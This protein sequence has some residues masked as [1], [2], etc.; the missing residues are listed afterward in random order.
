MT[1]ATAVR[2]GDQAQATVLAF[3]DE[4][5]TLG[6]LPRADGT[7]AVARV[8]QPCSTPAAAMRHRRHREPLCPACRA[9]ETAARTRRRA[10]RSQA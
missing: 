7:Y 1:A 2:P 9:A 8:P 3:Q 4:L 6:L 5:T 10:T